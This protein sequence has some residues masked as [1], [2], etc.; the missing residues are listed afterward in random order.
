[1]LVLLAAVVTG[2]W[3]TSFTDL[4]RN[5]VLHV[6]DV[7]NSENKYLV[8]DKTL[9][10]KPWTLVR[11]D[12][13]GGNVTESATGAYYTFK[14]NS[15]GFS[16]G[17]SYPA[18][19]TS[20]GITVTSLLIV[21][22][23]VFQVSFA[24][25]EPVAVTGVTLTPN[26]AQ[27]VVEGKKL[28]F[29]ATV[30]PDGASDK[31]VKWS[32][33]SGSD[34][35]KL[36]QDEACLTEIGS[37]ATSVLTVYAQGL[38][39]G[40]ATVKVESNDDATKYATCAIT[41]APIT[42]K[43]SVKKG[44]ED[45]NNWTIA[46]AGATTMGVVAGTTLTA[47]YSGTKKVKSVKAKKKEEWNGNLDL[48]TSDVVVQ[49]HA[50]LSGTLRGNYKIS[51]ADGA[52]VT[53]AGAT[54]NGEHDGDLN[55]MW[56][57]LTCLGDATIILKDNT[58]NTVKGFHDHFPA[59][60]IPGDR[61]NSANNKTLTIRGETQGTGKL[62]ARNNG[63]A[64]A[65]GGVKSDC[66]LNHLELSAGNIIIDGGVI[67]AFAG[68]M[69]AAIGA[70][71][72][73]TCGFIRITG[74]EILADAGGYGVGIGCGTGMN[75]NSSSARC[76][77][78][79]ITGGNITATGTSGAAIGCSTEGECGNI[80]I[81][82]GTVTATGSGFGNPGIGSA[83]KEGDYS[84]PTRCGDILINGGRVT[85]IGGDVAPGIGSGGSGG[86][87]ESPKQCGICGSITITSGVTK[88]TATKGDGATNSIGP[89]E[90]RVDC[91]TVKIGGTTYW[92]NNAYVGQGA[93][94]LTKGTINYPN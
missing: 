67:E 21:D 40:E 72:S 25:R 55:Y 82:G 9:E 6:G 3:A 49:D 23:K 31:K 30:Q 91:G 48:V 37:D 35:V 71:A 32:V 94:Y 42:Y 17:I 76:G 22:I 54:I 10:A 24:V 29:T 90:N 36:Y 63:N 83:W 41:V 80:T 69:C 38:S 45:A 15:G 34:K 33:T 84:R 47:T 43:V 64:A 61:Y 92:Q 59:I 87:N 74:G 11:A 93:T 14:Y 62:I 19:A 27:S 68:Y 7:I 2:A 13:S 88:V 12:I 81:S 44:T 73:D 58:V 4:V 78:I 89:T 86:D 18:T 16:D 52:T 57:G 20:E 8:G 60:Y 65:I 53:L 56:A 50:T 46:P 85:A 5:T 75:E 77:D 28:S 26:T 70:A 39:Q 66:E 1:M 79:T 51:I